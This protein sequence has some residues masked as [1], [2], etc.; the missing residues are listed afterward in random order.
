LDEGTGSFTLAVGE[1]NRTDDGDSD[2][3]VIYSR[4]QDEPQ[5]PQRRSVTGVMNALET[6]A[7]IF[8]PAE[9]ANYFIIQDLWI[10][11]GLIG[12]R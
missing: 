8:K 11:Y 6:C 2:G 7:D 5:N 4:L 12:S 10:R 9:R 3:A 1:G